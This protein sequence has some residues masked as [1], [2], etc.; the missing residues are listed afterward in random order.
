MVSVGVPPLTAA[1]VVAGVLGTVS[2]SVGDGNVVASVA[3][4]DD[5]TSEAT[6]TSTGV[7][8]EVTAVVVV[9]VC[10]AIVF[11]VEE[12]I[13]IKEGGEDVL[14]GDGA[15]FSVESKTYVPESLMLKC[16]DVK[17]GL[18]SADATSQKV[19][20]LYGTFGTVQP[21]ASSECGRTSPT[22]KAT[23]LTSTRH[24]RHEGYSR[25]TAVGIVIRVTNPAIN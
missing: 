9:A 17:P 22:A 18:L 2:V 4:V 8:D 15:S 19:E 23:P 6:V 21:Q 14:Y 13:V 11:F 25:L 5:L 24:R 7:E 1:S 10:I 12:E 20:P 16:L 3:S